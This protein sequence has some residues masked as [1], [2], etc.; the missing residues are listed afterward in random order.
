MTTIDCMG[1]LTFAWSV[2]HDTVMH[3]GGKYILSTSSISESGRLDDINASGDP[4]DV[5]FLGASLGVTFGVGDLM[6]TP[7][8]VYAEADTGSNGANGDT[9]DTTSIVMFNVTMAAGY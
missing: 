1:G 8:L 7:E 3:L 4:D 5:D 9:D 6:L 2:H